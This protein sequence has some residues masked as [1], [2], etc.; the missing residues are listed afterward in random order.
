MKTSKMEK[1][2]LGKPKEICTKV[3]FIVLGNLLCALAI[4]L[5]FVPNGLLSGGVG[6][7]AIM[8][9]YLTNLPTGISVFLMNLPLFVL[10]AKML[11]RKF[12]VYAF[13]SMIVFSSWLTITKGFSKYFIIDDIFLGSVFGAVFNGIGMG[14]MFRHG[15]CQGGFDVIAAILKRKY[16]MNIGTGLMMANTIIISLSSLLFGYKSAMYTLIAMYAGYQILDKVQIGFNIQKNVIIVSERSQELSLAIIERIHRGVTL[17]KGQ[18]GYTH[19]DRNIIY[20]T[21]TSREIAKLKEIVN[22][23]DPKAFFTI[24]DVVEVKGKGFKTAEI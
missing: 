8:I 20:C 15:T 14:L 6:G 1:S 16:N 19:E 11:D 10:G 17:L 22:D 24:T 21:L 13:I 7:I 5:F 3:F 4:N 23:V 2:I 12:V 9:Q 18:G